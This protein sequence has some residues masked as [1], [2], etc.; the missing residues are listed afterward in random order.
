[1][2]DLLRL[3]EERTVRPAVWIFALI[4]SF[5][6]FS[7][8]FPTQTAFIFAFLFLPVIIFF[9]E[10]GHFV[11]AK[12]SGMLVTEFFVGL[13]PRVWSFTRG[14]TEYGIK[15]FP[16]GG[17]C[18]IIGMTNLEE[19][20]PADEP[21]AYRNKPF[22]SKVIVSAAGPATHFVIA[23]LLATTV[24]WIHG[25]RDGE[26]LTTLDEISAGS[27]A[28]AAGLLAGDRIVA[29]DGVVIAEWN[30]L[31]ENIGARDNGEVVV[32][33]YERDGVVRDTNVTLETIEDQG[34]SRVRAGVA[35]A[36]N[37][38]T[39]DYTLREAVV[40]SPQEVW[41]IGAASIGALTD[42]FSLSGIDN[43]FGI[44]SGDEDADETKRFLSP[45]GFARTGGQAIE[46][47]WFEA[48]MLL[49]LINVFIGLFNLL[50]LLPFD[51]GH[52]AIATY[53]K[54]ASTIRR[55]PVRADAA[56]LLPL[57]G[58]V[59]AIMAFIF[60]TSFFLD[61]VDPQDSPF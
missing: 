32:F 26:V 39:V 41:R 36:F 28:E 27:P 25:E 11:T 33:T 15:A 52:I 51:G 59:V 43:Y 31:Y 12:R 42:M 40:E 44:L 54:V 6:G 17:Y 38:W 3:E 35:P 24:L 22:H 55:R 7:L 18:R 61:I 50:P 48:V 21:R 5:A 2:R 14:E 60:M 57:T 20:A 19:V 49:I 23:I 8:L 16:V 9:H 34:V 47:G 13:G 37:E 56:K 58:V 10:L 29:V 30:D 46:E 1:M 53:E 4:V 45:V